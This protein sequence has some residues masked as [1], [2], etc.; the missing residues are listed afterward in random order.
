M[1]SRNVV[2]TL[3]IFACVFVFVGMFLS[4][5][6]LA[7]EEGKKPKASPYTIHLQIKEGAGSKTVNAPAHAGIHLALLCAEKTFFDFIQRGKAAGAPLVAEAAFGT[8]PHQGW[9]VLLHG[10]SF[11]RAEAYAQ[12]AGRAGELDYLRE[13]FKAG[14]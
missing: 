12:P 9:D 4:T 10:N 11:C 7:Q 1:R 6:A 13:R 8:L 5:N 2:R 3:L 14:F